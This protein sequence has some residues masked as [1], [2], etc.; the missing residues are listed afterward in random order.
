MSEFNFP[1]LMKLTDLQNMVGL[2]NPIGQAKVIAK[3]LKKCCFLKNIKDSYCLY[4]LR[5]NYTYEL[6]KN[7]DD[8]LKSMVAYLYDLSF[9]SFKELENDK[10]FMKKLTAFTKSTLCRFESN[11]EISKYLP[12]LKYLLVDNNIRIDYSPGHIQFENGYFDVTENIFKERDADYEYVITKY[13][14]RKYKKS[15]KEDRKWYLDNVI[16]KIYPDKLD[17]DLILAKLSTCLS[18]DATKHQDSLFLIGVGSSGKSTCLTHLEYTMDI[19]FKELKSDTFSNEKNMDKVLNTFSNNPQILLAWINEMDSKRSIAS[20]Y[21]SFCDGVINTVKLYEEESHKTIHNALMVA[22]SNEMPNFI[23]DSGTKRRMKGYEHTSKFLT[24]ETAKK[25]NVKFDDEKHI[26]EADVNLNET[27]K[28]SDNYKNAIFDIYANY[29]YE[30]LEG[31]E[32]DLSTSQNFRDTTSLIAESNDFFQDFIDKKIIIT[33]NESERIGKELMRDLFRQT[34]PNKHLNDLQIISSLKDKKIQYKK[35]LRAN[36]VRGCFVGVKVRENDD[37]DI[38][39]IDNGIEKKDLSVDQ[40]SF[41]EMD[42]K[43]KLLY[44]QIKKIEKRKLEKM[45]KI[46]SKPVKNNKHKNNKKYDSDSDSDDFDKHVS[47][48]DMDAEEVDEFAGCFKKRKC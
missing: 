12:Q 45:D 14:N 22:T 42:D 47:K 30:W 16:N 7:V 20:I 28:R 44:E 15:K 46:M 8:V 13:I 32:I 3:F 43:I 11:A 27:I 24:K 18:W 31:K 36:N 5:D 9:E 29:C 1:K 21:K 10:E 2:T 19:Y 41:E 6:A 34:Y 23:S 39:D 48:K 25:D 38:D 17:R 40:T 26:Y 4:Y 37:A 35:D 33:N